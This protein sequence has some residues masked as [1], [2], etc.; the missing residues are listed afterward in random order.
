MK[1]SAHYSTIIDS[2]NCNITHYEDEILKEIQN[3]DFLLFLR[4]NNFD[5]KRVKLLTAI[6]FLNMAPLHINN[7]DI[8]L[9]FKS[10]LLFEEVFGVSSVQKTFIKNNKLF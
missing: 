8:F 7:F 4:R 10:K 1:D 2:N 9:F 6:I 5:I 3:T